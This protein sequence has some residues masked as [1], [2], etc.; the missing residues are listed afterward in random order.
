MAQLSTGVKNQI[1]HRAR[2]AAAMR[3]ILVKALDIEKVD[4]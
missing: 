3:P 1:S 2:A 4:A